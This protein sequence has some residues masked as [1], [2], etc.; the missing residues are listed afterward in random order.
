M[1]KMCAKILLISIGLMSQLALGH[2]KIREFIDMC[3]HHGIE[4][5]DGGRQDDVNR[6]YDILD[7]RGQSVEMDF[8][9]YYHVIKLEVCETDVNVTG[10][11]L[12]LGMRA[13]MDRSHKDD[14]E[15]T[16]ARL[17]SDKNCSNLIVN[18]NE[19]IRN[20]YVAA[21]D[22]MVRSLEIELS[23]GDGF[24]YGKLPDVDSGANFTRFE[25]HDGHRLFG[26]YGNERINEDGT[27]ELVSIGFM[28]NDC[29]RSQIAQ[30]REA[31]LI[32]SAFVML[33]CVGIWLCVGYACLKNRGQLC[34]KNKPREVELPGKDADSRA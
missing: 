29:E 24:A 8:F 11:Q 22:T 26:V 31:G 15:Y 9:T 19:Y 13:T 17:G 18:D 1:V 2:I 23:S 30:L 32:V 27:K 28:R 33:C 7:M 21:D 5:G 12:T 10:V 34:P 3:L 14:P 4:Q 6:V 16:L 25:F 20:I